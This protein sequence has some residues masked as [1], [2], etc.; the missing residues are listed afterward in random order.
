MNAIGTMDV[1][2][3]SHIGN[4]APAV[5]PASWPE[6]NIGFLEPAVLEAPWLAGLEAG[7]PG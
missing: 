7:W 4:L 1:Q 2:P 3:A 5:G 6:G